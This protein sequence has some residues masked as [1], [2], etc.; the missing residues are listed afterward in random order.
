MSHGSI[1]DV[2]EVAPHPPHTNTNLFENDVVF[3]QMFA[4]LVFREKFSRV[5][6]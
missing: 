5:M 6:I 2:L 1:R 3:S 4:K